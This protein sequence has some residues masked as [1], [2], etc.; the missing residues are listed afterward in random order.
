MSDLSE[1]YREV[2]LDHNK[3]PRNFRELARADRTA[4]G[5]NPLCG[6]VVTVYA[7]LAGDRL[8]EVA[9]QGAGC[10]ISQASASLMTE[11]VAGRSV[12]EAREL[13]ERFRAYLT[14]SGAAAEGGA[15]GFEPE[16]GALG[17]L[18]VFGGVKDY[19]MRVK[20]ATLAW[21]TLAAALDGSSDTVSTET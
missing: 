13:A 1:L 7:R 20:C 4:H 9:F 14:G 2:I 18:A 10:A 12:A 15:N 16:G 19:P 8:D 21:H 6:D 5:D 3:R 11:A 17:K